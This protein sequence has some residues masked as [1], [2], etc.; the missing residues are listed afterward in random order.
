MNTY[1]PENLMF[2][3]TNIT[4]PAVIA[5]DRQWNWMLCNEPFDYW[6]DGA[7]RGTPTIVSRLVNAA[8]WQRQCALF[9]PTVNGY[10]YGSAISP[11]NNVHQAN[12]H[13]GGWRL[14]DTTRLIWTNGQFDPWRDSGVSSDF[15]PGGP[16][17]STPQHPL[18]IIPGGFH[19]SDLRLKNG[20][21]NAGVQQVIDNEVAQIVAWV[22]EYPKK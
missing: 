8:Y 21:F 7:P 6:Q 15:R 2:S 10:T 3:S 20:V 18:Q 1:D 12:K 19:C 9:F 13:T 14:E 22:A 17:P 4:D 11:D 16:L 5:I